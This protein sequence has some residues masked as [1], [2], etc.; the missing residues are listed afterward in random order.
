MYQFSESHLQDT[1]LKNNQKKKRKKKK[2][3]DKRSEIRIITI[4]A[5]PEQNAVVGNV[6]STQNF[7]K[8]QFRF[9]GVDVVVIVVVVVVAAAT[10]AVAV[11]GTDIMVVCLWLKKQ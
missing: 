2:Q 10:V 7:K 3:L 8:G 6:L 9:V 5:L 11:L 4:V 1:E